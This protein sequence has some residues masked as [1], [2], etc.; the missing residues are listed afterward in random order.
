MF[1]LAI[2]TTGKI[3]SVSLI[4]GDK[5]KGGS[6]KVVKTSKTFEPMS[7]LKNLPGLIHEVMNNGEGSIDLDMRDIDA[8]AVSIGPGS[9]TGTRIGVTVARSLAQAL[10][11]P[12]IPVGSLEMWKLKLKDNEPHFDNEAFEDSKGAVTKYVVPIYNARRGQVYGSIFRYDTNVL[13]YDD[14]IKTN[15]SIDNGECEKCTE[16]HS[17]SCLTGNADCVEVHSGSCITD[18]A[19]CIEVHSGSCIT[20]NADCIE[21]HSGSCITDNAD[22]IEIHSA[23]CITDNADCI[24]VHSGSCLMLED[25]L[26]KLGTDIAKTSQTIKNMELATYNKNHKIEIC[27][28]GDGCK[29]YEK[30]LDEW[31]LKQIEKY[32]GSIE[33]FLDNIENYSDTIEIDI[34]W[35][36]RNEEY[37]ESNS[38][39]VGLFAAKVMLTENRLKKYDEVLP[40]YMRIPE[41]EA[42]LKAGLI[43]VKK[44]EKNNYY[45]RTA[46]LEDADIIAE[47]AT[48]YLTH[49]WGA[50]EIRKDM[51]KN[52]NSRYFVVVRSGKALPGQAYRGESDVVGYI[53]CWTVLAEGE[54]HD[55]VVTEELRRRGLGRKLVNH[56]LRTG[57]HEGICDFTLEVRSRNEAAIKLYEEFGFRRE[58][59]RKGYYDNEDDA[60]I[61]WRRTEKNGKAK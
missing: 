32:S 2:E 8:I 12:V 53:S 18:N 16:V 27:F 19:D 21:V 41:A 31:K 58:G 51:E 47:M 7:H 48:K 59:M 34:I 46:T 35:N 26:Q 29:V 30:T 43:G 49:S 6:F 17:A 45:V 37:F 57:R 36:S 42:K 60:V 23:S 1:I 25:L 28:Y 50:S 61:M 56:M 24:E 55:V 40:D 3:G 10:D 5:S 15:D 14:S 4:T 22:C 9:F 33:K 13:K 38:E 11:K 54:I 20:D 39:L 52:P 44:N